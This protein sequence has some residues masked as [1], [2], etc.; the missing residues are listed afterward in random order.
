MPIFVGNDVA[1]ETHWVSA[2][3]P[4]ARVVHGGA[5][6][7]D[8][9]ALAALAG[10]L[11]ALD[12]DIVAALDVTGSI[13]TF[14]GA[15]P[16]GEGLALVHVPGIAVNRAGLG[17]AGG[18]RKSD[19][20]DARTI[21]DLART[22][23]GLR[24]IRL[25]DPATIALRLPVSRRED[26][27]VDQ[28]RRIPRL[29]QLL[30]QVHPGLARAL[31]VTRKAPLALLTRHVTPTEIRAAG[32][33]RITAP[34]G[35]TPHLRATKALA[36][37]V[38]AIAKARTIAVPG[39]VAAA[40]PVRELAAEA[41]AAK[42][43]IAEIDRDPEGLPAAHPDGPLI[44]S[45]PG[46]GVVLAAECIA[47]LGTVERFASADAMAAAAGLA[48]VPRQSGRSRNLRRAKGGDKA[49]KRALFHS[50]FCAVMTRDPTSLAF[51]RRKRREGKR[52]TQ[53]IIALARR[54][55]SVPWAMLRSR[56]PSRPQQMA[57]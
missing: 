18:E 13:A 28:T 1:R 57:A 15:V 6:A 41:L 30:S 21:A 56:E 10:T 19:P 47:N 12:A 52:H 26:L 46:T 2:V 45:L 27:T 31:D 8:Q 25:D 48:P 40:A 51:H 34:L 33:R 32:M 5:V 3:D 16:A 29:R 38:L 36:E 54:R 23:P 55:V 39:G 49:L 22:R 24:P 11:K 4:Q 53:A 7:N 17:Y 44:R 43:R 20:R 9:A 35:R 14:L 42:A 50:A 37:Q